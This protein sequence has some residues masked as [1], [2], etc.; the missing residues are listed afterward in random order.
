MKQKRGGQMKL[1]LLMIFFYIGACSIAYSDPPI[2]GVE[3]DEH[4]G[5]YR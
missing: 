2:E 3:C 5:Y 1:L 4:C